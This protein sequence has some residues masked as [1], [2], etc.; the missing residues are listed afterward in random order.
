MCEPNPI[1]LSLISFLNPTTIHTDSIIAVKPRA[2]PATAIFMA[3]EETFCFRSPP[4]YILRAMNNSK[5]KTNLFVPVYRNK[6]K[7]ILFN[8]SFQNE[9]FIYAP[10]HPPSMVITV[11]LMNKASSLA[12]KAITFATSMASPVGPVATYC[13]RACIPF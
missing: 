10:V 8:L 4:K 12:R 3:G 6:G 11:P 13:I 5:F 7:K 2:T 1:T 9:S